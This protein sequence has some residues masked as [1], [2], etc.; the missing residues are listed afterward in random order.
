MEEFLKELREF[1]K[2]RDCDYEI[3][4]EGS[5]FMLSGYFDDEEEEDES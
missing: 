1:M 2:G 4:S 3:E 5:A